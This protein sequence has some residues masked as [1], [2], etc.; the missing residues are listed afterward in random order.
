MLYNQISANETIINPYILLVA[1]KNSEVN[2]LDLT[3][4]IEENNWTNVFYEI[5][6][7]KNSKVKYQ[8]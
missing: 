6:L 3:S 5:Y 8:I 4:Y 7:E 1:N 2:F